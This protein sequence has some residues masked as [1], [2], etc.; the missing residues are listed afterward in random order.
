MELR[1]SLEAEKDNVDWGFLFHDWELFVLSQ[2]S[3][4][5]FNIDNRV[6]DQ[7][8]MATAI[9]PSVIVLIVIPKM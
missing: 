3:V 7:S 5:V 9:P 6:I 2:S 8:P 4:D 1:I